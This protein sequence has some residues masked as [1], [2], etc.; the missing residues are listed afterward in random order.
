LNFLLEKTEL[1]IGNIILQN[2]NLT[3]LAH[4]T[5]KALQLEPNAVMVTDVRNNTVTLDILRKTV[6]AEQI[7]GK[8][9]QLLQQLAQLP[10]VTIT[11][12]TTIDSEGILGFIALNESA[13]KQVIKRTHQ[14]TQQIQAK[15]SKRG[16]IQD[17]NTPMIV[18]RL[19]Q[20]GYQLVADQS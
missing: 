3:Q 5:A 19:K 1:Y 16:I 17:T 12:Q 7:F 15:I 2:V 18:E 10:S 8:Q 6:S 9:K 4:V 11:P 20:A 13:A 14:I